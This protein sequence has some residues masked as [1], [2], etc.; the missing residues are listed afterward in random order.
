MP[1]MDRINKFII[2]LLCMCLLMAGCEQ[3]NLK[4]EEETPSVTFVSMEDEAVLEYQ[5]P[6]SSPHILVDQLGYNSSSAKVAYFFGDE[7]PDEFLV[8]DI[9]NDL[10]VFVGQLVN[11]G[12]SEEYEA[13]IAYGDF[14]SLTKKGEYYVYADY[15]GSSYNFSIDDEI[16]DSL[17]NEASRTY[18]YNRC[19]MTLTEKNAGENAH[20]ACHTGKSVLREDMNISLDVTGGWHQDATGSKDVEMAATTMANMLLAYELFPE[21]FSD[22]TNIPESGNGIPD[23]LDEIKYE[24]DWLLKMQNPETGEVYS[25]VTYPANTESDIKDKTS[26]V[27]YVEMSS[28]DSNRAFAFIM[29][30]YSYI[31]QMFDVEYATTCLK[32]ADRAWKYALLKEKSDETAQYNPDWK[33]AAA[34]E[35]YRASGV[36][37]CEK[38]LLECFSAPEY[39]EGEFNMIKFFGWA[40]YINSKQKV[41]VELC[42]NAI[43]VI[44]RNAEKISSISRDAAFGVEGDKEQ[45][46]NQHILDDM[47]VMTFVDYIITNHEYDTIIENNLHY[48]L[49][50]NPMSITYLD[51]VGTYNY[52]DVYEGLGLMKQFDSASKLIFMLGRINDENV[53]TEGSGAVDN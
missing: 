19:G 12:Y 31:Y 7:I 13:N 27:S 47:L 10:T 20:N 11:K 14:S 28:L 50:R 42:N 29:A 48:F 49:G 17:L 44:M 18:Y 25:A 22:D 5:V 26:I 51:N 46:N 38:E 1:T 43:S 4:A 34:S 41:N 21:T 53:N 40:A 3:A 9:E 37:E 32:A 24:T 45:S 33:M 16:Y 30:K 6:K 35:I 2:I 39:F 36:K 52:M 8:K 23:I 15:L